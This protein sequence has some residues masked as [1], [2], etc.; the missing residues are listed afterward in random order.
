M[1]MRSFSDGLSAIVIAL[2]IGGMWTIGY[3]VAPTLFAVLP[4]HQLAGMIA[5]HIFAVAGWLGMACATFL[6]VFMLARLGIDALKRGVFWLILLLLIFTVASQ[7]GVQPL[8]AKLKLEALPRDVMDSV[9]RDRFSTWHGVASML[10]LIQSMLGLLLV[11]NSDRC[12][13]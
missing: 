5:G 13:S 4:D 12:R 6:L 8:I 9:L 3:L 7:F 1:N 10:Y 2:W 11:M